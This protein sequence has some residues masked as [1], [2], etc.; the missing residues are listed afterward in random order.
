M[1]VI[2]GATATVLALT[3]GG[4]TYPWTS[5]QVLAPLIAGLVSIA[6]FFYYEMR[7]ATEPSVPFEL[8][9]NSTSLSGYVALPFMLGLML[10]CLIVT[11]GRFS[12]E[13]YLRRLFVGF[14]LN[15]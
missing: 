12:T 14:S 15:A 8:L 7:W 2:A 5:V 3:W 4:V 10:N 9:A 6:F 1:I 11:W 13:F